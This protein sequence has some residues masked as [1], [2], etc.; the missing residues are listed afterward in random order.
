[1]TYTLAFLKERAAACGAEA[2]V[3]RPGKKLQE[4]LRGKC[5]KEVW[6]CVKKGTD[7][8]VLYAAAVRF[9]KVY[10]FTEGSVPYTG[11]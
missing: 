1:M 8:K 3:L 10:V 7:K 11:R 2:V 5:G 6:L 4:S 9:D